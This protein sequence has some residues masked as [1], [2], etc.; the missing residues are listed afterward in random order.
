MAVSQGHISQIR[1]TLCSVPFLFAQMWERDCDGLGNKVNIPQNKKASLL[2]VRDIPEDSA[3]RT[4]H[5]ASQTHSTALPSHGHTGLAWLVA[6][7]LPSCFSSPDPEV[8]KSSVR[9]AWEPA[10]EELVELRD[11]RGLRLESWGSGWGLSISL[12]AQNPT[13]LCRAEKKEVREDPGRWAAP[14]H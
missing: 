4:H 11:T 14:V 10:S 3:G 6:P 2:G 12:D 9:R 13:W 1:Q 5:C 8:P 7:A